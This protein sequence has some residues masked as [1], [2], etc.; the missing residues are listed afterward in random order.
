M[1]VLDATI[2]PSPYKGTASK[3]FIV[4]ARSFTYPYQPPRTILCRH[5]RG[6]QSTHRTLCT[7]CYGIHGSGNTQTL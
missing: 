4:E 5:Q 2:Q 1:Y 6:P 3:C 7:A